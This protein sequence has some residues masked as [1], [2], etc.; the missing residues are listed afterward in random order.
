MIKKVNFFWF[1]RDLRLDDNIGLNE[2]LNNNSNVIP[3]FIFDENITNELE[4]NDPRINFIYN[5]LESINKCLESKYNSRI[6]ILKGKP[7][8]VIKKLAAE[9]NIGSFF[10][11]HDYEPYAIAR[12]K[13]IIDFLSTKNI[14]FSSYKDQVIFEKDEITKDDKTPY[15]VYTPYMKK[16]KTKLDSIDL[17]DLKSKDLPHNFYSNNNSYNWRSLNSLGFEE[18]TMKIPNYKLDK[19]LVEKYEDKRNFPSLNSTSKIGPHLRFGTVSI[20]QVLLFV[21][22]CKNEVFLQELIWREFFMQIIWFFPHTQTRC[23]KEKYENVQ[24][25]YDEESFK[26]WCEGKTGYP[27]VDAGMRELNATGFMHNRVRMITAGFLCK[28]L[29]IDWRWGEAYFAKKLFDYELSS[30]IGN[31]QWAAGTGVDSA[32]YFRI[33]NPTTQAIK[34]DKELKYINKW[35]KNLNELDY[36]KPIIDHKFARQRCLETYKR[37]LE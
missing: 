28:H 13:K 1:R 8:D 15:V 27:I 6:L 20:R 9:Y 10:L 37:G 18:S 22:K 2:A 24:W 19:D 14:Q 3:L 16:W 30:N 12:D 33:F 23:F 36:P 29:L 21:L 5:Q 32:P 17:S 31:W 4:K 25:L 34:F 35:V 26:K 7:L 11:N